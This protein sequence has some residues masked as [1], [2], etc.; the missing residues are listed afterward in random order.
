MNYLPAVRLS[1]N[2]N[3]HFSVFMHCV[4]CA[5][6]TAREEDLYPENVPFKFREH[7]RECG[8]KIRAPLRKTRMSGWTKVNI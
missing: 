8:V 5:I 7:T 4:L 3:H 2:I 1:L 6:V